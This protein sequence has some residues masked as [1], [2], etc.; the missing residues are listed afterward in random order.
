MS[1]DRRQFLCRG[2][3]LAGA[4]LAALSVPGAALAQARGDTIPP[5]A[6]EFWDSLPA[7]RIQCRLCP[8]E[9][10]VDDLERGYCGV[11]E[12]RGGKYF[13]EVYGAVCTANR[14][15]IEK[16]PFFHFLPASTA[17][18]IATAGCNMDCAFCQNW[19]ISQVR[20]EQVPAR[21][22]PPE[23]LA[24]LAAGSGCRSIAYTYSEPVVF[25]EY[26]YDC[27]RAGRERGLRSVMVSN[28]YIR[29]EPLRKLCGVLDGIKIDL[30]AFSEKYYQEI[31]AAELAPVL[32]SLELIRAA[33]VW[34]ELVYL[35]V[36]TLNDSEAEMAALC[37]WVADRLGPDVPLHL[38]RFHPQYRLTHLPVTPLERLERARQ[39]ALE[40][41]LRY[42]YLGNVPGHAAES[43]C[44][45]SCRRVVV[46]RVGFTI[47]ENHLT[48][49]KCPQCGAPIA[50][51]WS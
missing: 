25:Y 13:T 30:K 41:G 28:G 2:L 1:C 19:E 5:R 23:R 33:G 16:K 39:I 31:C 34:L 43:T 50:G 6:A 26:M 18:S 12:N 46:R 9:C 10:L 8:R 51:C 15:P 44:C 42:V 3:G 49:G 38:T 45:P 35:M 7:R 22:L 14:D 47:L 37:A 48:Q 29:E 32:A 21:F 36:P 20:P 27:A 4:G 24:E 40:H 17:F 11:R